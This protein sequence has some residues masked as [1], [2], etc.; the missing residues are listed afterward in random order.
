MNIYSLTRYAILVDRKSCIGA[1][2][3]GSDRCK[4]HENTAAIV[5]RYARMLALRD[6][7]REAA[8]RNTFIGASAELRKAGH[9]LEHEF[10]ASIP[11]A[12]K[13]GRR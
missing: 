11:M 4:R 13:E 5:L 2:C 9:A 1:P 6:R 3:D 8:E 10:R 12:K 7:Q